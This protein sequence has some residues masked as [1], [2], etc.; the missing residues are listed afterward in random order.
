MIDQANRTANEAACEKRHVRPEQ[1][2]RLHPDDPAAQR[3]RKDLRLLNFLMGHAELIARELRSHGPIRTLCDIGAGD[4][5]FT[6][7]MARRLAWTGVDLTLIDQHPALEPKTKAGFHKLGWRVTVITEDVF[8]AL[9]QGPRFD[10]I[11]ANLFLHHFE[12]EELRL[13]LAAIAAKCDLFVAVE[14]RRSA[15]ALLASKS[16]WLVGCGPVTRHDAVASVEAGFRGDELSAAW[17]Q[18]GWSTVERPAGLFSHFFSARACVRAAL[19][20]EPQPACTE[21][22]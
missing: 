14:P 13:L 4:G 7:E 21:S 1:L 15:L 8:R 9:S 11:M 16:I 19:P 18:D 17:P 5:T 3:S 2:D 22:R 12:P 6:L 10:A 20:P